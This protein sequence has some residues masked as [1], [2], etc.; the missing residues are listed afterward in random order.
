MYF[1]QQGVT[2][3]ETILAITIGVTLMTLGVRFYEQ[4][5]FQTN[6]QKIAA[7]VN[8]LFLAL[9]GF[10]YANCRQAKDVNSN[11][12]SPGGLDPGVIDT[13]AIKDNVFLSVTSDLI[14]PQFI[15]SASWQPNN[16]LLD[17][18][19]TPD[20]GYY[21]QF[22]RVLTSGA[23]PVMNV[24]AC[25]GSTA[26]PSCDTTNIATLASTNKPSGQSQAVTWVIQVAVKL[27]DTLTP[28]QWVQIQNDLSATCVSS[29]SGSGVA[30]CTTSP[31]AA[32][33]LVWTRTPSASSF[34]QNVPSDYWTATP[35]VKEFNMQ[36]TNDSMGTLSG[37][38]NETQSS[39][40]LKTW[41]NALYYLCG[42]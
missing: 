35:Y 19:P 4:F 1:K 7:N 31:G 10:Y 28:A 18:T 14:G 26:P 12:Q 33:Y 29:P 16:P 8:Q 41:N 39:T 30:A 13:P 37:V 11:A 36:Y 2:L 5:Q 24:T 9:E 32:G 21:I 27:A 40:S 17:N 25:T 22:N 23:D 3:L 34:S 6:E 20:Q 42:G 15:S 38:T